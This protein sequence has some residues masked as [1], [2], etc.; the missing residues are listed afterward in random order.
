MHERG[1]RHDLFGRNEQIPPFL[2]AV[3]FAP[4]GSNFAILD[5]TLFLGHNIRVV[6][7]IFALNLNEIDDVFGF[8]NEVRFIAVSVIISDIKFLRCRTKPVLHIGII[9]Q[10]PCEKQFRVAI[11]L[12]SVK[13][14]FF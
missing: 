11:K 6:E 3:C 5:T 9:F 14:I 2:I 7:F 8:Y 1:V 13:H 4:T 12:G 10:Y